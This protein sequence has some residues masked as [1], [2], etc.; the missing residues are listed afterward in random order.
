MVQ[1][2]GCFDIVHPGHIRHL[3][4]A[5]SYGDILLVTITGDGAFTKRNG[6]PLIPQELRAEALAELDCVDWVLID[7]NPTAADLLEQVRPDVYVK[8]KEYEHNADARFA[9]ER[10]TVEQHGGRV[11]FSSGDVVFSSTALIGQLEQ[12]VDPYHARLRQLLGR[13]ELDGARLT[14]LISRFKGKRVLVVGETIIDQY[15]LCDQPEVASESPVM[16]LRPLERRSYDGG[17]AVIAR[18]L[19][20]MGAHPTLV[21]GLPHAAQSE[22]LK[23]RL[24]AEGI[25]VLSVPI[26]CQLP[27]KQRFLVGTQKVMKLNNLEPITLDAAVQDELI[28]LA[29]DAASGF[30]AAIIADFGNGLLSGYITERLCP[31]LRK[32]VNILAGD[33]S[34]RRAGLRSLKEMDLLCPSESEVREAYR[35]FTDS[36]PAVAAQLIDDTGARAALL[37]MGADG[38]I[39]FEPLSAAPAPAAAGTD[40]AYATRLRSEHVPAMAGFAVDPLGCGDA[41]LSAATLALTAGGGILEAAFLG[42]LS[43]AAEAQRLGNIPIT[44]TDLRHGIVRI[45]T[46]RL[47]FDPQRPAASVSAAPRARIGL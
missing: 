40:S 3:R 34:G 46:S 19:A 11:V 12:S 24:D 43:A 32:R 21:T 26:E 47:I 15:V 13:E 8:G 35:N 7:N 20:A 28:A 36:I 23:R 42:S 31:L 14:S 33:I 18:H 4:Q 29:A 16:T 37:T 5:R 45:N 27:E 25:D 41:L 22:A 1:C 39:A 10:Q 17:A 44:A 38:L 2:H 30:D 6:T 9:Q